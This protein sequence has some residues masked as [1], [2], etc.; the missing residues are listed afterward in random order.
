[1][2]VE[3]REGLPGVVA[4]NVRKR[5]PGFAPGVLRGPE[6]EFAESGGFGD[7]LAPLVV[8]GAA[9]S[10]ALLGGVVFIQACGASCDDPE[11]VESV[12][13]RGYAEG[14][15]LWD[16]GFIGDVHLADEDSGT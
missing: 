6:V 14:P 13:R 10:E 15:G 16:P 8:G 12:V 2:P 3:W 11:Q 9:H 7:V 4:A 5:S 1:M